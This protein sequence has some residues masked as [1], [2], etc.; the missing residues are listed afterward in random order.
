MTAELI[1]QRRY[2][3][4]DDRF[5]DVSIWRLAAPLPPSTHGFK[6]RLALVANGVCLLRYDNERSKGDHKHLGEQEVPY[7][8]IGLDQLVDDF[9]ADVDRV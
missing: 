3:L 7:T 6:Y 1:Q 9:W 8:F 4:G 5:A 2:A